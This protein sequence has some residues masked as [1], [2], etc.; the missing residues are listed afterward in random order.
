MADINKAFANEVFNLVESREDG[1]T[2]TEA[3]HR[4][5]QFGSNRLMSACP[6]RWFLVLAKRFV[7]FFSILLYI[8]AAAC[9]IADAIEPGQSMSVLGWALIAVAILNAVFAYLQEYRAERAMAELNKYLP[10]MA[11]LRRDGKDVEILA[12]HIVSGD[13]LLVTEGDQVSADARVVTSE[14]L[15]VNNAPLTGEARPVPLTN[16]P[17]RGELVDSRNIL[18][19]GTAVLRG[20]GVAVVF[21]T[22][23]NTQFGKIASLS[24]DVRRPPSPIQRETNRM[25]RLLTIIAVTMGTVFFIYGVLS[26]RSLWA[27]LVFMMGIIVANVPDGLLPTLTL[28]LSLASQ[29]MARRKVL[30]KSLEAVEAMGAMHIICTDKT[31]PLTKNELAIARMVDGVHG[32]DL[33]NGGT[34]QDALKVALIASIVRGE[35][36]RFS[37]DPLDVC[38][39]EKYADVFGVPTKIIEDTRRHF[40]FDLERR[41]QAGVFDD[42]QTV[43]F[44]VKGAWESIRPF[45]AQI[46]EALEDRLLPANETALITCDNIVHTMCSEGQRVIATAYRHLDSVPHPNATEE[47]LERNLILKGFIALEDPIRNDVPAAVESCHAAGIRVILVT[48]DHP[49]TAEAVAR[50]CGILRATDASG[51]RIVLGSDLADMTSDELIERLRDGYRIRADDT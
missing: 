11:R 22:G 4:L 45:I 14:E 1:L 2:T 51:G 6:G 15:L 37:G 10:R 34:L 30:V 19:A 13:V 41:R 3:A 27:N 9:F 44:A 20:S 21:A 5:Q 8:S 33:P 16:R 50:K 32:T 35:V 28:A 23:N 42:G 40:P 48:G 39:V 18:F 26:G 31:G 43:L 49:D 17:A 25:V 36:G 38:I 12:D 24:R 46:E 47:W 7:N 29:R